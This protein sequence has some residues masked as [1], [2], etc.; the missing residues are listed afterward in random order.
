MHSTV[1]ELVLTFESKSKPISTSTSTSNIKLIPKGNLIKQNSIEKISFQVPSSNEKSHIKSQDLNDQNY[2]SNYKNEPVSSSNNI[3]NNNSDNSNQV[4]KQNS[5]EILNDCLSHS[6]THSDLK[7]KFSH[8]SNDHKKKVHAYKKTNQA[9]NDFVNP[10]LDTISTLT[11]CSDSSDECCEVNENCE[12]NNRRRLIG[13]RFNKRRSPNYSSSDGDSISG[14][15]GSNSL[16]SGYKSDSFTN[17]TPEIPKNSITSFNTIQSIDPSIVAAANSI[18]CM[19]V[20]DAKDHQ[21]FKIQLSFDTLR[22][23]NNHN[24]NTIKTTCKPESCYTYPGDK[25]KDTERYP[26][27][28][29]HRISASDRYPVK[30][31]ALYQEKSPNRLQV[32]NPTVQQRQ[33][34]LILRKSLIKA[35]KK[36]E[37]ISSLTTTRGASP[38]VSSRSSSPAS[39]VVKS[40]LNHYD[41]QLNTE[42]SEII[43]SKLITTTSSS[44]I[45]SITESQCS[46]SD[47]P[48][49]LP[50]SDSLQ[51]NSSPNNKSVRFNNS[52]KI[53]SLNLPHKKCQINNNSSGNNSYNVNKSILKDPLCDTLKSSIENGEFKSECSLEGEIDSLLYGKTGYYSSEILTNSIDSPTSTYVTMIEGKYRAGN[54]HS[55]KQNSK[56]GFVKGK[57]KFL[58]M[59]I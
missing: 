45:H 13:N 48:L 11:S 35:L 17:A 7:S 39:T 52:V 38:S 58:L 41:S 59:T 8:D 24:N 6:T 37:N 27:Q 46:T 55:N 16:D 19:S 28:D 26:D 32:C 1:E 33:H 40:P 43:K 44:S 42:T 34:L 4:L 20:H 57:H 50:N 23:N 15:A 12:K 36:C 25:D 29:G 54:H 53:T 56:K 47:L 51:F 2:G 5:S 3:F 30:I 18:N 21:A 10:L 14:Y 31:T 22:Y 49:T 9:K